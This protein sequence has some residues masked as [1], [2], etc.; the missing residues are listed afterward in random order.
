MIP[1][2][3][4]ILIGGKS[5]RFGS[6]KWKVVI[7]GKTVLD[8]IWGSCTEFENRFVV[9]KEKHADLN[10]PFIHDELKLNAPING[11]YTAL[12]NTKTDWNL[13]LSCDLPLVESD[14]FLKLWGPRNEKCDA[15]IPIANGKIQVTCGFYHK[16]ILPTIEH[17]IQKENYSLI[18][19]L[20]KLDQTFV[21]F[22]NDK[23]F[24]NM[25]TKKDYGK[26]LQYITEQ[27]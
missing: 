8:R 23:R 3:A 2:K 6:S 12:K 13:L 5:K 10:K 11:L 20:E 9:G 16:R 4:F 27:D 1:A 22:G 14:I 25:N 19:L 26:I 24:W 17:E 7:D 18:K 15:V 21:E